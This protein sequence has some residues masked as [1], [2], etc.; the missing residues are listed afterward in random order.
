M[1]A[2]GHSIR[3]TRIGKGSYWG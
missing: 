3:E 2:V 1:T